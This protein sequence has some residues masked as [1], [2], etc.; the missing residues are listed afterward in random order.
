MIVP[1][2]VPDCVHIQYYTIAPM[3]WLSPSF[4]SSTSE[5]YH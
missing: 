4:Y 5:C 3:M 1:S 2:I